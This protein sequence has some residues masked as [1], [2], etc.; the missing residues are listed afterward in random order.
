MNKIKSFVKKEI[1]LVIATILAIF[2][3]LF[4]PVNRNYINYIDFRVLALLFCLMAIV[5]GFRYVDF[6]YLLAE[7]MFAVTNNLRMVIIVFILL[8]FFGSMVITNDVA[9]I[10]FVPFSIFT[11]QHILS[12]REFI[13]LIVFETIAANL[14][15]MFTPIGNP[16]NLYLYS[17]YGFDSATFFGTM[18]PYTYASFLLLI[19]CCFI[20]PAKPMTQQIPTHNNSSDRKNISYVVHYIF[21]TA[22]FILTILTVARIV[23]YQITLL[24][25][26]IVIA[27]LNRSLFSS[28]DYCLLLTFVA[29]FIFV[30]NLGEISVVQKFMT[31][32]TSGNEV[33]SAIIASQFISNV[34]AALLLSGFTKNGI[35]LLIGT[36]LGGLGTLIASMA[37][38]ISYKFYAKEKG[39]SISAYLLWF[40]LFNLVFLFLL[41]VLYMLLQQI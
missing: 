7:K 28:V 34:P 25:C 23:P 24:V 30:G 16:Q 6:F 37:S 2:S 18:A 26:I 11:L 40:T 13:F 3:C 4:V 41:S 8:C 17:A 33:L 32:I 27:I 21:Y 15:S 19:L 36:N 38:L 5:A 31:R 20:F 35:G 10:L 29:F 9:L 22:L 39:S 14:G 1:V 12:K